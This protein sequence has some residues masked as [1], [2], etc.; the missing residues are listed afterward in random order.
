MEGRRRIGLHLLDY[1]SKHVGSEVGKS[2][3]RYSESEC[4]QRGNPERSD[5]P[6]LPRKASKRVHK[7]VP[8]TDTGG[9]VENT[10]ALERTVVKELNTLPP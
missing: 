4:E 8:E 2:V 7:S 5:D 3:W 10:K 6:M 9:R 1:W